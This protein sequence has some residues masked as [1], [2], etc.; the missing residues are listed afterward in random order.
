M[1]ALLKDALKPNLVQTPVSY[2][3]LMAFSMK[4]AQ[5]AMKIVQLPQKEM[6]M[7]PRTYEDTAQFS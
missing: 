5:G 1:T 7:H 4:V 3:H 6:L 2:T